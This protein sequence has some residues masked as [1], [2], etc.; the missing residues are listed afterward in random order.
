[1]RI[2]ISIPPSLLSPYSTPSDV[3]PLEESPLFAKI[4]G[5]TVLVELQG[6]LETEGDTFGQLIGVL[7]MEGVSTFIIACFR[8]YVLARADAY[9]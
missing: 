5:Q 1:M 3:D 8:T 6:T 4:G 9:I 7:G 2:H